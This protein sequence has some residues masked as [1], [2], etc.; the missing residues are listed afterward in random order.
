MKNGSIWR[1]RAT[2]CILAFTMTMSSLVVGPA[3]AEPKSTFSGESVMEEAGNS[4]MKAY[5][6]SLLHGGKALVSNADGG[7]NGSGTTYYVD[8]ESGDDTNAGTSEHL[9]WKS[10]K[11]VNENIY[12]PGDKILFKAG[13]I[14]ENSTLSPKGSG[15]EGNPIVIGAYNSGEKPKLVGNSE[16]SDVIYLYN[17]EYWEIRD[18]EITNTA[19]GF[20]GTMNDENGNKLKDIRGIRV[21]G[22]DHGTLKGFYL[23]DLYV[24][25]VTGHDAWISGADLTKP[26]ILGK[27]GWDK[28]KRTG[29]I[30]FEI[31]EPATDEPTI[32]SDILIE[33]NV[34]NNNSFGGI[35]TKQWKG[36][37]NTGVHW[38]SREEG[39]GRKEE[40]YFCK[41]WNP[42]T[43]ITV[44]DNFLSQENSDYA[45]DTIYLTS[46][47]DALVEGNVSKE[48][49]TCGIELY[50][51][52][53]VT[54]QR[55]EVYLTRAKAGGADSCGIDP[56]KATTN[57]LVQ[58]NYVHDTGDGILLCGFVFGTSVVRYNV[59]KDAKKRYIN[60]HGDQGVNYIYNNILYNTIENSKVPFVESSGGNSVYLSKSA[61]KHYIFNNIFYNGASGTENVVIGE[62]VSTTYDNNCYY[63]SGIMIPSQ[64]LRPVKANPLF[65]ANDSS[66]DLEGLRLKPESPLLDAGIEMDDDP[67]L[68]ISLKGEMDFSGSD[69]VGIPDIG[70]YEYQGEDG[71]GVLN[72]YVSDLY[73]N[74]VK[75]ANVKLSGTD[76]SAV[77]DE[78]GFFAISSIIPGEYE[79]V[80]SKEAY[81]NGTKTGITVTEQA[82]TRVSLT[83][84]E[85]LT[86]EGTIE[87][88][89]S[90]SA[91]VLSGVTITAS[92][93]GLEYSAKTDQEGKYR[94][95]DVPVGDEYELSAVKEGYQTV[96]KE[97]IRVIPGTSVTV[98]FT[99]S[100]DVSQTKY[101]LADSF[102]EY[103]PGNFTSD[104][105]GNT[106]WKIEGAAAG[107]SAVSIEKEDGDQ[108]LKLSKTSKSDLVVYNKSNLNLSGIVTFETRVKRTAAP[109]N[110]NQFG[111]YSYNQE[112]FKTGAPASSPNPI[113]TL[114]FYQESILSHNKPGDK[115]TVKVQKYDLNQWYIIRNVVNLDTQTFDFYVDDMSTP[116]L[117]DQ[118]L[119]TPGKK[120]DKF[121]MFSSGSNIGDFLVDYFKVCVGPAMNYD[122]ADLLGIRVNEKEAVW[123]GENRYEIRVA[124]GTEKV[125]V[126]PEAESIF[127]KA[128][129][130]NGTD[131]LK[132]AVTIPITADE[133]IVSVE[134]LAEDGETGK[135]YELK[136]IREEEVSLAYL[137]SL[138]VE[139][140]SLAPEFDFNTMEYEGTVGAETGEVTLRYE[141]VRPDNEVTVTVN[142]RHQEGN[143]VPLNFGTNTIAVDV[144]S[145]DGTSYA[146]YVLTIIREGSAV[147]E[148]DSIRIER[149]PNRTVYTPGEA[150]SAEG[151]VVGGYSGEEFV[152]IL[153]E[154]EYTYDMVSLEE[155]GVYEIT[156]AYEG[157]SG[158]ICETSFKITVQVQEQF[159]PESIKVVKQPEQT[160]YMIGEELN[161]EGME[162]RLLMK[163]SG[164][165]AV[166]A[167]IVELQEGE[168]EADCDLTAAGTKKVSI[169]YRYVDEAGEEQELK[170]NQSVR[171]TVVD[172]AL[173]YYETGIEI[174]EK[175]AKLVYEPDSNFDAEGM[176]VMVVHTAKASSSNA[177]YREKTDDYEIDEESFD[178]SKKGKQKVRILHVGTNAEG[179]HKIFSAAVPVTVT[180]DPVL[181]A[182]D[183]LSSILHSIEVVSDETIRDYL[184][185]DEKKEMTSGAVDACI[186]LLQEYGEK[187]VIT[188][189]LAAQ[190]GRL[191]AIY[192]EA[193]PEMT[194]RIA[195][196]KKWTDGMKMTGVVLNAVAAG[197]TEVTVRA[198]NAG[199]PEI[200]PEA[201]AAAAMEITMTSGGELIQPK[202]PIYLTMKIPSGFSKENLF[203]Y[204]FAGNELGEVKSIIVDSNMSFEMRSCCGFV[205][206]DRSEDRPTALEVSSLPIKT[207]Y[208]MGEEFEPE[209]LKITAVLESGKRV[210]VTDFTIEGFDSSAVGSKRVAVQW[211][212]KKAYFTVEIN[213]KPDD[214]QDENHNSGS[215]N[216]GS[217][218][219][220][221][222]R[223]AGNAIPNV[224]G[225]WKQD[226][227]GWWYETTA[228]GY[229]KAEWAEIFGR[230]Y[231]F[232]EQGYMAVGWISYKDR[233][234]Y[235]NPDGAMMEN[236]WIYDSGQWYFIQ[237]DG[238]MAANAW[239]QW[240]GEW[241]Y[242]QS[243]GAMACNTEITVGC[244]LGTDG[245]WER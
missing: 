190:I 162:V 123:K 129:T 229:L 145:S 34:I 191:E 155:P 14:W 4:Q 32:F 3:Y 178:F 136:I 224:A 79:A 81:E 232:N 197:V 80:I 135:M 223:G 203:L 219:G 85:C 163:A 127:V 180:D 112:D 70:A 132:E 126:K 164:S 69:L 52:D 57:I 36:D 168:Y 101:L 99:L 119:R 95:A 25:D 24:H 244:R 133:E 92:F 166:P 27:Q 159:I 128:M 117:S 74:A 242:L 82:V 239:I 209:G 66:F 206:A 214:N 86:T 234:Y 241:Y 67:Y 50:Y 221:N 68:S 130:V 243:D 189:K 103:E 147:R 72:G 218:N 195:G 26:G 96:W 107:K 37:D 29:G 213:R 41:N 51:A 176:E 157:S 45:C 192:R 87:G 125:I 165:N 207:S 204:Y 90:N 65:N 199:L 9:P 148:I 208:I 102:E 150:F 1:K 61:N 228:G 230:W 91:G 161:T 134:V 160:L 236:D 217:G 227:I 181:L 137:T 15:E 83:L 138:S 238:T 175:P 6:E 182:A 185:E 44:R 196:D 205:I 2:A 22:Q 237:A 169:V 202:V 143:L 124:E 225:T 100:K 140:V 78:R 16:I 118:P 12:G 7:E 40:N 187:L 49:G 30:L 18:L 23:H 60:P 201:K 131:A 212:G 226:E 11:R 193:N 173:E 154:Q 105:A 144:E 215:E 77:T 21:A 20:T 171:V 115:A 174:T 156:L 158:N 46:V 139:G 153:K 231:Y 222:G 47:K 167:K 31:L 38:A 54:I 149:L 233:W 114:A 35:I 63:G 76:Y 235:L 142:Q 183:T 42:H 43:N 97:Q 58:Y 216:D 172:G 152:G 62:G 186:E 188:P 13:G 89:V 104:S 84:G 177:A 33:E 240:K 110:A 179:E 122:D 73:G 48:A 245:A 94:L 120:I 141:T 116:K 19:D 8:S 28:S 10:I 75:G 198:E 64:D 113:A 121:L 111:I 200:F 194:I 5:G 184:T 109:G 98:D 55:N 146:N 39:K 210:E 17:Q 56:D 59:I 53:Q 220:G 170:D 106:L 211:Q 88:T 151:L 93:N 108:Y 71:I